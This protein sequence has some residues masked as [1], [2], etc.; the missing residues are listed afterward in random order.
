MPE[1][2]EIRLEADAI[3][4]V[5][6]GVRLEAVT[7]PQPRISGHAV[8][9]AASGVQAVETRGKAMLIRFDNGLTL[10]SHNQLYGRWYVRR[11]GDWPQTR[12]TLRVA[13]HTATHSALLYSASDIAVLSA[14]EL[15]DHPFLRR[16]G[17]DVLAPETSAEMLALRL[18]LPQF[19]AR[20]LSALFLD[21]GLVVGSAR[22]LALRPA[23]RMRNRRA[24]RRRLRRSARSTSALPEA[25]WTYRPARSSTDDQ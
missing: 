21:Q 9:L 15:A 5:L 19:Q 20:A 16:L 11:R 24:A 12:R 14:E 7:L 3:A 18:D 25:L 22:R 8:A 4:K 13:L 10:F 23:A 17:P 6:V 1:G 2:P